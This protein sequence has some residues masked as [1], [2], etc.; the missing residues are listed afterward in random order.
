MLIS[1]HEL[2]QSILAHHNCYKNAPAHSAARPHNLDK[3]S[4]ELPSCVP[5]ENSAL[6]HIQDSFALG[7]S[8]ENHLIFHQI[9]QFLTPFGTA[10]HQHTNQLILAEEELAI[11]LVTLLARFASRNRFKLRVVRLGS[12]NHCDVDIKERTGIGGHIIIWLP[13]T[14][15]IDASN[16]P[17]R[18][19]IVP[20][21]HC[22]MA[23]NSHI[24]KFR[25]VPRCIHPRHI[26]LQVF[27]HHDTVANLYGS[28]C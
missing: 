26:R 20:C 24:E 12:S 25:N 18:H 22:M 9:D 21:T 23:S 2:L 11:V 10:N 3:S 1:L 15:H 6:L 14:C 19:R 16:A 4:P 13:P 28:A 27:V 7:G 8:G 5:H 17:V